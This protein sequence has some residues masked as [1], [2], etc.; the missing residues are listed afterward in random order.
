MPN[1]ARLVAALSLALIAFFVSWQV[2]TLMPEGTDF[3]WFTHVN[4]AI[5]L[6]VGWV[7]MGKRPG[8]GLTPAI[9]NGLTGM[10]VMVFWGLF[11]QSTNEMVALAMRHRYEGPLDAILGIFE[12]GMKYARVLM[13]PNIIATLLIG[14][15]LAGMACQYASKKWR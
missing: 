4:I 2:M 7:V 9:N 14:G 3:G 6:I 12:I 15:V 11:V 1:A 13:V 5:G 8:G 10:A